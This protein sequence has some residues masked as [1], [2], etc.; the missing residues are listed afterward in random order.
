MCKCSFG[1]SPACLQIIPKIPILVCGLP[2]G[3]ITDIIP[4]VNVMPFGMCMTITN[5][6]VAAATAAATA[7]ALGVFTLT[8]MPC[9][10][11]IT[12]PWIPTKPTVITPA[13]PVLEQGNQC[14]CAW[15]GI[16]VITFPG[17]ITIG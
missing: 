12:A 8:P 6:T 4:M 5:P 7:A 1:T 16:I 9:V 14:C 3:T 10:P 13:G 2:V 11:V 17:Q 15:G